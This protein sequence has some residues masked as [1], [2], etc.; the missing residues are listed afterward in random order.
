MTKHVLAFA[1]SLPAWFHAHV[2]KQVDQV[3][4]DAPHSKVPYGVL[5]DPAVR[6]AVEQLLGPDVVWD[7][8]RHV[9]LNDSRH[10]GPWHTDDY[11]G[12]PWPEDRRFAIL[13][14]FPQATPPELGP[15]AVRGNGRGILAAGPP[16]ACL[17]FRQDVEHRATANTSGERRVMLKYLFSAPSDRPEGT[18]M[19]PITSSFGEFDGEA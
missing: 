19:K 5:N 15:T 3:G 12:Q 10:P 14:Y 18:A 8:C 16:G 13:C 7:D 4:D 2:L 1:S 11:C 17:L 9:H 6:H